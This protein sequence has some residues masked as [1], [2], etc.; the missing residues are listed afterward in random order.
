MVVVAGDLNDHVGA[1]KD[2]Y[3]CHGGFGYGSRN[4]D[5]V[6][7]KALSQ[8]RSVPYETV[9]TQ[10][11]PLIC[12]LNITPSRCKH[13]DRCVSAR[14]KWWRLKEKEAAVISRILLPTVTTVDESWKNATDAITR[15]ACFELGMQPELTAKP[16]RRWVHRQ[17]WLWTG[18]VRECFDSSQR[19]R[20]RIINCYSPTSAADEAEMNA[21]YEQL[22]RTNTETALLGSYPRLDFSMETHYSG[23][24]NIVAGHGSPTTARHMQID[25]IMLNR[26]RMLPLKGKKTSLY[27]ETILDESLSHYDWPIEEDLTEEHELLLKRLHVYCPIGFNFTKD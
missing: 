26:R 7:T 9:A 17:A 25:H 14:I 15:A 13:V 20:S 5:G 19:T 4:A 2:G 1:A 10:H 12:S 21:F 8:T 3:S 16:G 18:D 24:K 11:R 22:E 23:R 27:D 6:A